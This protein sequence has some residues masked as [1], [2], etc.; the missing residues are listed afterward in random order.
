M[1]HPELIGDTV[2]VDMVST[3]YSQW[4]ANITNCDDFFVYYL[5]EQTYIYNNV[6]YCATSDL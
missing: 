3:F 2:E 1:S 5:T 6:R 4:K